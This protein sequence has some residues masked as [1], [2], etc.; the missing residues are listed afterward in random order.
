MGAQEI[1]D[2]AVADGQVPGVVAVALR[3]NGECIAEGVAGRACLATG[4][5]MERDSFFRLFSM[6]KAV[7]ST[8][9]AMLIE[10]GSLTADTPVADVLPEFAQLQVCDGFA[11]D[12]PIL[13]EPTTA[14]TV[15]H[16][17][18]HTSGVTYGVWNETQAKL[19]AQGATNIMSGKK[20]AL[21]ESPMMFDPGTDWAYG[22]GIDWLSQVVEAVSGQRI[23]AFLYERLF[24]PLGMVDT[25]FERDGREDRLVGVHVYGPD[26]D[27][28]SMPDIGPPPQP[29]FYGMGHALLGTADDYLRF[30]RM[31]LNGGELDGARVMKA[32][33]IDW[34]FENH[35]GD[36]DVTTMLSDN[37]MSTPVFEA[38]YGAPSKHGFGFVTNTDDIDGLRRA[39][40]QTWAGVMNTHMWVD[41]S[42]DVAGVVMTQILPFGDP[43]MMSVYEAF[44]REVYS[45]L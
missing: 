13:R 27:I 12:V 37:R 21:L 20:A 40:S 18:T 3:G 6:S 17:A 33:T 29:E 31:L 7:G 38:A 41:P 24:E 39:G 36:L 5:P 8:A 30:L 43:R 44:E 14:C 10:D 35:I 23:D 16:L 15:R 11:S 2:Q 26:G 9:A 32:E 1:L 28:V 42:A 45:L 34:M 4:A 25:V 19:D 22:I